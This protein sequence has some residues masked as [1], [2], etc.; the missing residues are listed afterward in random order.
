[1][2]I[3][4]YIWYNDHFQNDHYYYNELGVTYYTK[5]YVQ[6]HDSRLASSQTPEPFLSSPMV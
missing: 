5:C 3:Y 6:Y 2:Y 1:M 4:I